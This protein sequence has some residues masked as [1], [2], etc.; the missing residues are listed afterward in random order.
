M[1][2]TCIL[3]SYNRP[4]F[5]R[6]ALR[7]VERQ[8]HRDYELLLMDESDP[9]IFDVR[10][11]RDEFHFPSLRIHVSRPT[12]QE[13][14][15]TNR[16]AIGINQ[17]LEVAT[18]DLIVYLPDDDYF[19]QDWFE[20]GVRFFESHPWA[21]QAFGSLH[22]TT[23]RDMEL[24]KASPVRF[25]DRTIVEPFGVLDHGMVM[26]RRR[27]PPLFW[28]TGPETRKE[29]DGHFFRELVKE[30]P[31]H[32]IMGAGAVVKRIHEKNFQSSIVGSLEGLRE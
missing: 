16:L 17:A 18:G 2:V 25:Y 31:F 9:E 29:P 15:E 30:G 6:Q 10:K 32:P 13:R 19:F 22:Y 21:L 12:P 28:P 8:T 14:H 5:I 23:T 7:S 3:S 1:K 24:P 20:Q 4:T 26:H 11:A 27:T